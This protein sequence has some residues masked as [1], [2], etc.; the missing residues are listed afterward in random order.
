MFVF[1]I[2]KIRRGI[3]GSIL[4]KDFSISDIA[5]IEIFESKMDFFSGFSNQNVRK[6][7]F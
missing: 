5:K 1:E 6:C 2:S 3:F 7:I 4:E